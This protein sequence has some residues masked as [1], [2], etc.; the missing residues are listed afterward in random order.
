MNSFG[1]FP[2]AVYLVHVAMDTLVTLA[3]SGKAAHFQFYISIVH[4]PIYI[5]ILLAYIR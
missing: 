2:K 1:K 3:E 5:F 4:I